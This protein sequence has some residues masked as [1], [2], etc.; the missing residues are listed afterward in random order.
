M[1]AAANGMR[2]WPFIFIALLA[3]LLSS[4]AS[5]K[6]VGPR[7]MTYWVC[8]EAGSSRLRES[9]EKHET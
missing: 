9:E 6:R 4:S 5:V 8:G 3:T 7:K 2:L 1:L